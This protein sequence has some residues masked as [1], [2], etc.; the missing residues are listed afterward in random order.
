M[1][2]HWG[3]GMASLVGRVWKGETRRVES[4]RRWGM[5]MG[6]G[7]LR[8]WGMAMGWGNRWSC[9]VPSNCDCYTPV[10]PRARPMIVVHVRCAEGLT[11]RPLALVVVV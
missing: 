7:L 3:Q 8:R 6:W 10:A 11:A 2:C 1:T 5:A 4:L 9:S